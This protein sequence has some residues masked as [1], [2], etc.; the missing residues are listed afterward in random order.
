MS[1]NKK[2]QACI[3]LGNEGKEYQ[4]T[5]HNIGALAASCFKSWAVEDEHTGL[6]FKS[7]EGFMNT[8]GLAI[9]P[10]LKKHNVSTDA[11]LLIHDDSDLLVGDYK[12]SFGG[13]CA[14]HNGVQSVI[15]ALGTPDFWRLRIGISSADELVRAKALDF[16]LKRYGL[17]EKITFAEVFKKAWEELRSDPRLKS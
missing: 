17:R 2:I 8:S 7:P 4:H 14:G 5:Y 6:L 11:F 12:I 3:G 13:G 15:D 16:V 1:A 10:W 9:V